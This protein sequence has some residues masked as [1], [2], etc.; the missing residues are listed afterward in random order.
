MQ[1]FLSFKHAEVNHLLEKK[2]ILKEELSHKKMDEHLLKDDVVKVMNYTEC[3]GCAD[4]A[5]SLL[6]TNKPKTFSFSDSPLNSF[7]TEAESANPAN[8]ST[9]LLAGQ[10]DIACKAACQMS[11]WRLL[12]IVLWLLWTAL[13]FTLREHQF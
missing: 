12:A 3:D 8:S 11:L 1:L 2:R 6:S 4:S 7:G 5:S 10:S 13:K 9:I